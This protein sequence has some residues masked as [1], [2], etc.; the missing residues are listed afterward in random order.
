M[1]EDLPVTK[2]INVL[3]GITRSKEFFTLSLFIPLFWWTTLRTFAFR[4]KVLLPRTGWIPPAGC[5]S[6]AMVPIEYFGCDATL[7]SEYLAGPWFWALQKKYPVHGIGSIF[8]VKKNKRKCKAMCLY[9]KWA[10]RKAGPRRFKCLEMVRPR[11]WFFSS[12][13]STANKSMFK[14]SRIHQI[15][16]CEQFCFRSVQMQIC[17]VEFWSHEFQLF[18]LLCA[19]SS[20]K[21]RSWKNMGLN[22]SGV[23]TVD[24]KVT[25][26]LHYAGGKPLRSSCCLHPRPE[27]N[28]RSPFHKIYIANLSCHFLRGLPGFCFGDLRKLFSELLCGHHAKMGRGHPW[29]PTFPPIL[30]TTSQMTKTRLHNCKADIRETSWDCWTHQCVSHVI[31][32]IGSSMFQPGIDQH[33]EW[34]K[35]LFHPMCHFQ[36]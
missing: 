11:Y 14:I 6:L 23:L 36:K 21:L 16:N 24:I 32:K 28:V 4:G 10:C 25:K 5:C 20:W 19:R 30:S 15:E 27:L 35:N 29:I 31:S 26:W 34:N 22:I 1:P 2:C 18:A 9:V 13:H 17:A 8:T 33:R 12:P 7:L 3:V